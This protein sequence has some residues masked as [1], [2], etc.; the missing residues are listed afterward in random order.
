MKNLKIAEELGDRSG[1]GTA[2]DNLGTV[3]HRL[4]DFKRAIDYH[5]RHLK[6]AKELGDISGKGK[7]YSKLGNAH[8]SLGDRF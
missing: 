1:K 3:H 8:L 7:A 6:I 5:E 2:Y 4:G